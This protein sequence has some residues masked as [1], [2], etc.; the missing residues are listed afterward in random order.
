M[1]RTINYKMINKYRSNEAVIKEAV[2]NEIYANQDGLESSMEHSGYMMTVHVGGDTL[3]PMSYRYTEDYQ[4]EA[5]WTVMGRLYPNDDFTSVQGYFDWEHDLMNEVVELFA[6]FRQ[7][8]AKDGVEYL[9]P[10]LMP[11]RTK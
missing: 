5:I 10:Q 11:R 2:V 3:D 6:G 8:I 4:E 1:S 7:I 9:I